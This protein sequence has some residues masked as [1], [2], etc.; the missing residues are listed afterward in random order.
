MTKKQD[1]RRRRRVI[2]GAAFGTLDPRVKPEDDEKT[3]RVLQLRAL[4]GMSESVSLGLA[5]SGLVK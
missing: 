4:R 3:K 2:E 5:F 1:W